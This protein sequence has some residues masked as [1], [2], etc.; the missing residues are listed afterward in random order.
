MNRAMRF[1]MTKFHDLWSLVI[2]LTLSNLKLLMAIVATGLLGI[3]LVV[4]VIAPSWTDPRSKFYSSKL[5]YPSVIRKLGRPLPVEIAIA[6][7]AE[8]ERWI[9]G[10]GTCASTPLLAPVIPMA[11]VREVLVEP[12]DVVKKDQVLA[13]MDDTLALIKLESAKLAVDT[14]KAELS[15]V[16]LGS[17]Y[18]LAQERPAMEK[19][20]L[21]AD[22]ELI[23]QAEEKVK[24]YREAFARGAVSRTAL[25]AVEGEFTEATRKVSQARLQMAMSE[26]GVKESLKIAENA[27]KDAEEAVRHRERELLGYDVRA[28]D[29]GIVERVLLN[30]GEY[31]QDSGKPGFVIA[32]GRW[33]EAYFDQADFTDVETGMAAQV[34]L[35]AFPGHPFPGTVSLIVPVVSF[36]QGGPETNRPL[37]PR[38][39]GAAE[40]AATFNAR[41][42]LTPK[43]DKAAL[44]MTGFAR[45]RIKKENLAIPRGALVSISAGTGYISV[46]DENDNWAS[47]L[48]EV[49]IVEDTKVEILSGLNP[50]EKVIVRGHWVLEEGDPI[51]IE[52]R[53]EDFVPPAG[54]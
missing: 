2:E 14:A 1:L 22:E 15:R 43:A 25:L 41:I 24:K 16:Q 11:M 40:W 37:R 38:G 45:I 36:N 32:A 42:G 4:A 17:A 44:G 26:K 49:G 27:V 54:D 33:F 52:R 10:E 48:V 7:N 23:L 19:V 20:N 31:N 50:G 51:R 46:V 35:E 29:A 9:M 3:L 6:K 28:P 47:R 13:R 21:A 53:W 5:G 30:P 34:H 18:V 39:S 12:G 8:F